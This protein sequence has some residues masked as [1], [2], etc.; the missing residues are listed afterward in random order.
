[1]QMK[2]AERLQ[3]EWGDKPCHHPHL[4]KEYFMGAH[5]G[6]YACTTCGRTFWGDTKADAEKAAAKHWDRQ[7]G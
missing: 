1:M 5:T 4:T 3:E 2:E 6:D 7:K